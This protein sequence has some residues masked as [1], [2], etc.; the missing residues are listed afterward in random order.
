MEKNYTE[1]P[2]ISYEDMI[3]HISEKHNIPEEAVQTVLDAEAEYLMELGIIE[4]E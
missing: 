4:T 1:V 2:M 3:K